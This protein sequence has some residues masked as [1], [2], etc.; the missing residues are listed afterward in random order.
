MERQKSSQS[1]SEITELGLEGAGGTCSSEGVERWG[2]LLGLEGGPPAGK[3]SNCW[4][5]ESP[6]TVGF[7][8]VNWALD[9]FEDVLGVTG[10]GSDIRE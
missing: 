6:E 9:K 4:C 3:G 2:S 8:M 10:T 7:L 5:R 1:A